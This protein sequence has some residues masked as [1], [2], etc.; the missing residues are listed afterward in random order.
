MWSGVEATPGGP[1]LPALQEVDLTGNR[2]EGLVRLR[3]GLRRH[4]LDPRDSFDWKLDRPIYPGLSAFDVEDAAIF[5]GRQAESWEAIEGLRRLRLQPTRT[6]KLLLITGASGS[7]KSSVLRAGVV[8]RL[9]KERPLWI[10][11][12]PFRRRGNA[13]L[14][15]ASA[16]TWAW[17]PG[18]QP[19]ANEL[20]ALILERGSDGLQEILDRLR[21]ALRRPEATLVLPIDQAEELLAPDPDGSAT[22][23]LDLLREALLRSYDN[24]LAIAT[25]R[26][27]QVGVWQAH[28]S[29]KAGSNH[30]GLPFELFPLGPMPMDRG[31]ADRPWP[32]RIHWS[33]DRRRSGSRHSGRYRHT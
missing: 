1:L 29:I 4:G 9:G 16:L 32:R 3:E 18:S 13:I 20:Q 2:E 5:F 28:P 26:S 12:R 7:G 15:L 22:K 6:P 8:A 23:L 14:S 30:S 25:I 21:Q 33:Y 27:D 31:T 10:A 24:I 17:P 19:Q 11:A